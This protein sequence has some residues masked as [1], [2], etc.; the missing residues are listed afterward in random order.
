ME[1]VTAS[2]VVRQL[3]SSGGGGKPRYSYRVVSPGMRV[4]EMM[5]SEVDWPPLAATAFPPSAAAALVVPLSAAIWES[6][7]EARAAATAGKSYRTAV[8][9]MP[10]VSAMKVPS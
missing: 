5:S 1:N 2:V 4:T 9:R 7:R 6:M 8:R 3:L 10:A